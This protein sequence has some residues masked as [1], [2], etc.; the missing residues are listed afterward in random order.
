M[1]IK[2]LFT[3]LV[4]LLNLFAFGQK[5]FSKYGIGIN[6][7]PLYSGTPELS[8]DYYPT[9]Y[10]GFSTSGGYTYKAHRGGAIKVGDNAE[11][12]DLKGYYFKAGL[13]F[14]SPTKAKK[15]VFIGF[16]QLNYIY[17]VYK[18]TGRSNGNNL[19]SSITQ[20]E[21]FSNAFAVSIGF[22]WRI[23]KYLFLR[24]GMQYALSF[25]R[26][27]LGY[28]GHTLQPGIGSSGM[29]FNEQLIFGFVF[30]FSEQ[31]NKSE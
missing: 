14:R 26:D 31:K 18:E 8:L 24:G 20:L 27:H 30:K 22:E 3:C 10:L 12:Y 23:I 7:V 6:F 17:S 21:G 13:K 5:D 11:T 25:R 2:P 1:R 4:L 16:A 15:H 28:A 29:I 9:K 19:N